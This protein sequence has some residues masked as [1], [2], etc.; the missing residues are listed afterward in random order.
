MKTVV[1][2]ILLVLLFVLVLFGLLFALVGQVSADCTPKPPPNGCSDDY[3]SAFP[4]HRPKLDP[5]C[6]ALIGSTAGDPVYPGHYDPEDT[7][8]VEPI[9]RAQERWGD[10]W[11]SLE[12]TQQSTCIYGSW[13]FR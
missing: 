10:E 13:D 7:S 12:S 2:K 8:T 5:A 4:C 6:D 9:Y 3:G 1:N 11:W